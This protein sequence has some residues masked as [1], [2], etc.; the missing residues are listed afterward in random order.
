MVGERPREYVQAQEVS[1]EVDNETRL[2]FAELESFLE[3]ARANLDRE[4]ARVE[5]QQR[6]IRAMIESQDRARE[7]LQVRI[8]QQFGRTATPQLPLRIPDLLS[9]PP[10][11]ATPLVL[12][13]MIG[14]ATIAA[15]HS[16][17]P[18]RVEVANQSPAGGPALTVSQIL[19]RRGNIS[20]ALSL[21]QVQ[22]ESDKARM[23]LTNQLTLKITKKQRAQAPRRQRSDVESRP[24]TACVGWSV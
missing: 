2:A 20:D 17:Q 8:A 15:S 3:N 19:H 4:F 7:A 24:I 5:A 18:E 11:E 22:I 1:G 6:R 12:P 13:R 21:T 23:S 16:V 14:T 10:R 9:G